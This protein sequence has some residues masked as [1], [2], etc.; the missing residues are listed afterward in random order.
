MCVIYAHG[1]IPMSIYSE[2]KAKLQ[3]AMRVFEHSEKAEAGI[4]KLVIGVF[5]IAILG[6]A[7]LPTGIDS[8]IAGS[9]GSGTWSASETST[10]DSIVIMLIIVVVAA[11]AGLAYK[12]FE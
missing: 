8:L 10:Y 11:L 5:I 9:N 3:F 2:M 12:A 6:G 4:I 1:D 7:L